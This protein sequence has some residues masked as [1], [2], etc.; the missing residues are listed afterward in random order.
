MC[1]FI[2][3]YLLNYIIPNYSYWTGSQ[4]SVNKGK[5][6]ISDKTR[7]SNETHIP[8]EKEDSE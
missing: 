5:D 6:N 7:V 4:F 2:P 8:I 1:F 3:P